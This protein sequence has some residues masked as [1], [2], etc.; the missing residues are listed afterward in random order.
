VVDTDTKDKV[1]IP[2]VSI[3]H[4]S[5]KRSDEMNKSTRTKSTDTHELDPVPGNKAVNSSELDGFSEFKKG[6]WTSSSQTVC[7]HERNRWTASNNTIFF[8]P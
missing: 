6:R 3:V 2:K 4:R 1:S 8:Y 5:G 7:A